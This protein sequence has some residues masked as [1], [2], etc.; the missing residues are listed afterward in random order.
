M[1]NLSLTLTAALLAAC[2]FASA[3][4]AEDLVPPTPSEEVAPNAQPGSVTDEQKKM[5]Q[6]MQEMGDAFRDYKATGSEESR[7]KAKQNAD[8]LLLQMSIAMHVMPVMIQLCGITGTK[9]EQIVS[10]DKK[11]NADAEA[12]LGDA[13]KKQHAEGLA[14]VEKKLNDGWANSDALTRAKQCEG[15]KKQV[16]E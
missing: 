14:D 10:L 16:G 5:D 3:P 11:T 15:L 7:L 9:A 12:T 6:Q 2:V 13:M 4:R 1:K 8:D